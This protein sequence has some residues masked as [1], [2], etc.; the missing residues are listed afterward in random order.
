MD[1]NIPAPSRHEPMNSTQDLLDGIR[2]AINII[3]RSERSDA[4]A[5]ESIGERSERT[6]DIG[7]AVQSGTHGDIE[8]LVENAAE[9]GRWQGVG[10]KAQ[11]ADSAGRLMVSE[12]CN[13]R[14]FAEPP[15]ETL[16]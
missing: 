7:G 14:N 13:A 11:R 1:C 5:H 16:S 12:I 4:G 15:G 10:A 2:Q 9:F 8:G 6:M 3:S